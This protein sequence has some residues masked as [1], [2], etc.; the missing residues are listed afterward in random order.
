MALTERTELIEEH[1][2]S[3]ELIGEMA[4]VGGTTSSS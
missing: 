4:T 1:D 3:N 2:W